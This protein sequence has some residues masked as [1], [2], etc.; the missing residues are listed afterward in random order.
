MLPTVATPDG[1]EDDRHSA[2]P[3][4]PK[5][6]VIQLARHFGYGAFEAGE[7]DEVDFSHVAPA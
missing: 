6:V 1:H 4:I 2:Q 5:A 7:R 3:V